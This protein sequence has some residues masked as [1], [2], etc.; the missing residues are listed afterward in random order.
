MLRSF[1]AVTSLGPYGQAGEIE[2]NGEAQRVYKAPRWPFANIAGVSFGDAIIGSLFGYQPRWRAHTDAQLL[3]PDIIP[4]SGF[5][6]TLK[7]LRTPLG[8]REL[9]S[10]GEN[11]VIKSAAAIP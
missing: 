3:R 11:V 5:V 9:V 7:D 2:L 10:D 6:G 1:S 8:A 4:T